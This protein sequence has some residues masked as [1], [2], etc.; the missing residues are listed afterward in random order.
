M[1]DFDG[2]ENR[3]I[4]DIDIEG[5]NYDRKLSA[6]RPCSTNTDCGNFGVCTQLTNVR[7]EGGRMTPPFMACLSKCT[8]TCAGDCR[9]TTK[10]YVETK[11]HTPDRF[12]GRTVNTDARLYRGL[13][14]P[15]EVDA[16]MCS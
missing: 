15:H 4:F 2:M 8:D 7:C 6:T 10:V 3:T 16:K 13:C 14:Y 5:S 12:K 9:E 11:L 1:L